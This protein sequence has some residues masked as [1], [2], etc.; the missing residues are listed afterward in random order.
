[1][2]FVYGGTPSAYPYP[3]PYTTASPIRPVVAVRSSKAS[4][5]SDEEGALKDV[6][7]FHKK[8]TATIDE[9][10][11]EQS[12]LL[13]KQSDDNK[14]LL[15]KHT[16]KVVPYAEKAKK[17]FDKIPEEFLGDFV[18]DI[19]KSGGIEDLRSKIVQLRKKLEHYRDNN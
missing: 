11:S 16:K 14:A 4:V 6:V 9:L 3:G 2:A 12:R 7:A 15:E 8:L 18:L 19:D 10:D 5:Q 17:L 1:M 13:K